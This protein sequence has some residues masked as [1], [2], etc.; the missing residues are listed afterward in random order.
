M[1]I[2]DGILTD[3]VFR[4][5]TLFRKIKLFRLNQVIPQTQV[6]PLNQVIPVDLVFLKIQLFRKVQILRIFH[7][8]VCIPQSPV[9]LFVQALKATRYIRDLLYL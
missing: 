2:R 6:I 4:K 7:Y 9:S 3:L 1:M 8:S 5:I